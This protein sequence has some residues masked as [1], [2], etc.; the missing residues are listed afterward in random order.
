VADRDYP[1]VTIG[2]PTYNRGDSYL[3]QA[4]ESAL[5]QTYPRTEVVVSDNCST[6]NTPILVEGFSDARIRYLRQAE[7]I[8]P[9]DNFNFCLEQ[10]RG[11]Y[12]LLL[13]DDDMIDEDF[14]DVCM[15]VADY[16]T[17][18][19]LIRTGMRRIDAHG[20]VLRER[21]NLAGGLS[22]EEF[23]LAWFAGRRMPMHLCCTLFN[24]ERL[25][26]IGGFH[27]RHQL[28]Q[29]VIAEVQL[30]AKF[31]RV[32]IPDVKASFRMHGGTRTR[33]HKVSAWCED[34]LMLLDIMCDLVPENRELIRR[35]GMR[36]FI[37]HNCRLA[38]QIESPI[39]RLN[40]YLVIFR[41]FDYPVSF[42][43]SR[44]LQPVRGVKAKLRER[45]GSGRLFSCGTQRSN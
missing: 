17:D 32:D 40:A 14:V 25:R 42:F 16:R 39:D 26:E 22:T 29:D 9:N 38:S 3:K 11:D 23:F 8:P 41:K 2:I 12:F 13:H 15:R 37:N 5:H 35:E 30:A 45:M 28:F 21:P 34:S 6:D 33:V 7:G 18:V 1:L 31:G 24:T 44:M 4:L 43:V 10:A 36:F 19:G 27:S 20:K